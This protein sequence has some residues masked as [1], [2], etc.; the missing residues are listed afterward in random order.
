MALCVRNDFLAFLVTYEKFVRR[1]DKEGKKKLARYFRKEMAL[2]S[3]LFC[4]RV[5]REVREGKKREKERV[6]EWGEKK[7]KTKENTNIYSLL[8]AYRWS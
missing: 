3:V 4:S 7:D 1:C 2:I 5:T 8:A 6:R